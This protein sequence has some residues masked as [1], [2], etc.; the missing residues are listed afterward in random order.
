MRPNII[1]IN[2]DQMR[3]DTLAHLGNPASHTP[4]LDDFARREGV[5]FSR[6]FC[7]NTVCVPSRCSFLTGLYPHVHGYRTMNHMLRES[8]LLK[9]LKEDGYYVWMNGRNDFLAGQ[10]PGILEMHANEVFYASTHSVGPKSNV[11]GGPEGKFFYSFYHGELGVDAQGKNPSTDEEA[12]EQIEQMVKDYDREEPFCIF[13]GLEAPH[14][15]YQVEA[16]YFEAVDRNMLSPRIQLTPEELARKPRMVQHLKEEMKLDALQE[17][18]WDELR[19]CYLG[20][21][22]KVDEYFGRICDAL[23]EKD[24]Y[25]NTAIFFFSDHGD[26]TGDYGLV[27]KTQNTFEDCLSNVPLLVKLPKGYVMAPGVCDQLVELIDFYATVMDICQV[28]PDH[29]HFGKSLVPL[30]ANSN[31]MHRE[32]VT[33]EGGRRKEELHCN[34]SFDK[35]VNPFNPYYP[36][37]MVQKDDM[38]HTKATML[39]TEHYK[40]VRRLYEDDEFYDLERDPR[41]TSNEIA[42]PQYQEVINRLRMQMLEWY[43]E[44]CDNVPYE[45]DERFTFDIIWNRVRRICPMDRETEIK[46][47]I[48]NGAEMYLLIDELKGTK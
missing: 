37:K 31:V 2:P 22:K 25:E 44:T 15:P 36:R 11:R 19:A 13:L 4:N 9:E 46:E 3:A 45:Q 6:A 29:T 17:S 23:K 32:F 7:Q 38:A 24:I 43:Q 16:P 33:S 42:A 27:E 26:Y 5:S 48:R 40:Y 41:E 34:E 20:M 39:R 21:C 47:R 28:T 1:I 18:D 30:L 14:P 10:I 8:S 35:Q 12:V